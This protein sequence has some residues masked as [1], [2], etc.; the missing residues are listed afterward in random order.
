MDICAA[1]VTDG[2]ATE[3]AEPR[4]RAFHDPAVPAQALAAVDPA[5]GDPGL[6]P[7]SV[8]DLP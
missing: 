2:E 4:Q 6:D 7:A 8:Q 3:A 5:S 1:L